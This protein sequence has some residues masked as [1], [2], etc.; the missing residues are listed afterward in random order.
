M[1]QGQVSN[2]VYLI[3]KEPDESKASAVLSMSLAKVIFTLEQQKKDT[4]DLKLFFL[5]RDTEGLCF[6]QEVN[7]ADS[8]FYHGSQYLYLHHLLFA[9]N[10]PSSYIGYQRLGSIIGIK[11]ERLRDALRDPTNP[12]YSPFTNLAMR[13]IEFRISQ[14]EYA[15]NLSFDYSGF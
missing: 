6:W 10:S 15:E 1:Q 2:G 13:Y 7:V 8:K 12:K 9:T 4:P 5:D 14:T 11:A 3:S